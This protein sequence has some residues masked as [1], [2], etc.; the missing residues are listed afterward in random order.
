M[1]ILKVLTTSISFTTY[2]LL[3]SIKSSIAD[4]LD[5]SSIAVVYK[6]CQEIIGSPTCCSVWFPVMSGKLKSS[7]FTIV[8]PGYL[9]HPVCKNFTC[10]F[11]LVELLVVH[12][13]NVIFVLFFFSLDIYPS[14]FNRV[15]LPDVLLLLNLFAAKHPVTYEFLYRCVFIYNE[16]LLLSDL[17]LLN[18]LHL[19]CTV[20]QLWYP[21]Q[22]AS[23]ILSMSYL[24]SCTRTLG[25]PVCS[26]YG[27]LSPLVML[28]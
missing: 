5:P 7:I 26:P 13:H 24:L 3:V 16:I 2:S 22:L 25:L 12:A 19:S 15:F 17:F 10:I 1:V 8:F 28:F 9:D 4:F 21:S 20:F 23:V 11:C 14:T 27:H 6:I 18:K